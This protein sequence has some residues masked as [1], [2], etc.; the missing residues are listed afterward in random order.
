MALQ[1]IRVQRNLRASMRWWA[2]EVEDL[3]VLGLLWT[4]TEIGSNL[5]HRTLFGMPAE[6]TLP[7]LAVI[8]CYLGLRSFKYG[9]PKAYLL[10]L[11]DHKRLPRLYCA[12]EQ[13]PV[14]VRRYLREDNEGGTSKTYDR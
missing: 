2:F 3:V 13:D 4:V 1:K 10:D 8:L 14:R 9:K 7:W 5:V 12:A 11:I 6:V